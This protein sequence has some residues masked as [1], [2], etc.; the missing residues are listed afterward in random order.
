MTL[1]K[2]CSAALLSAVLGLTVV[3]CAHDTSMGQR[4][5]DTTVTA[6]V[7]AALLADPDVKGTAVQVETLR[8]QVQ[9]SGFVD[10]E[11]Q[12]RRAVD[13][14]QRVEGVDRVINKMSVKQ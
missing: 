8:G 1:A 5:D 14:A 2:R 7:K 3:A 6:K 10:S 12:A 13:I 11:A 9:L 4:V